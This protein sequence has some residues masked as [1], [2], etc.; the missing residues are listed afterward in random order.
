MLFDYMRILKSVSG[1]ITDLS[2]DNQDDTM[3]PAVG[4]DTTDH[5]LIGMQY[6]F[7]NFF[8]NMTGAEPNS[9]AATL[10]LEY[11]NG[12]RWV[13]VVDILDGTA[14]GG[15]TLAKSGHVLFSLNKQES[16]WHKVNNP[17]VQGPTE[18]STKHIY[19]LYWLK[20]KVSAELEAAD[21]L[22]AVTIKELGFAW[23][24]GAKLK[25]IK[26]EVDR[27]LPSF[28]TSKANWIPEIMN[29]CKLMITDFKKANI[30]YGPQQVVRMDD[31]WIPAT[32]KSLWLIYSS[33]GPAYLEQANAMAHQ[34]Y[35]TMN[36]NNIT[37]DENLNGRPDD[38]EKNAR[39]M[40]GV[41]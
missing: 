2:Y 3:L 16:G 39:V 25:G 33:L 35:K 19:D 38:W 11:W 34:Y 27:Y 4:I 14:T 20:V 41:R 40:T 8:I 6:P 22:D 30:V 15:K 1:V 5:L 37:V 31:F 28:G 32:Y 7:N 12:S 9:V 36:V 10:D 26:S 13:D 17:T 23:T 29:A 18:L 21:P 24:T